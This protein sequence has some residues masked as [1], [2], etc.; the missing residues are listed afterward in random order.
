MH[1]FTKD[2]NMVCCIRKKVTIKAEIEEMKQK[3]PCDQ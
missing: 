3:S 2:E 1:G